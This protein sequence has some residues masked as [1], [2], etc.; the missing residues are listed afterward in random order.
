MARCWSRGVPAVADSVSSAELYDP[1]SGTWTTTG[2]MNTAR[3]FHTATLLSDGKVLVA[4]GYNR[5]H[6]F[7]RG[8]VRSGH[9]DVDGDQRDE[10]RTLWSYG[11][12]AA[13]W[14]GAGRRRE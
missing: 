11:D 10:H 13:Q 5:R 2:S 1:T 6:S 7:Q 9:R 12:V 4:G 8:V 14:E 3:S